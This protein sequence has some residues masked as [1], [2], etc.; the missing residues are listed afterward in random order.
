MLLRTEV[1]STV[2][3]PA[4]IEDELKYLYRILVS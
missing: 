3:N 1:A 4:D 2:S